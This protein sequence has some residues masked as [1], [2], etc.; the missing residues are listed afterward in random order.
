MPGPVVV[1]YIIHVPGC[2]HGIQIED[3]LALALTTVPGTLGIPNQ[4]AY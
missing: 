4:Y 3:C 2:L 1:L